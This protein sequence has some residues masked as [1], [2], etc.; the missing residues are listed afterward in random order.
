M[1][2]YIITFFLLAVVAAV[3]GFGGLAGDFASI[4]RFLALVFV[5]LFVATLIYNAITGRRISPP[6]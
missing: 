4:A 3:A 2:N 5:V 6:M 1:L